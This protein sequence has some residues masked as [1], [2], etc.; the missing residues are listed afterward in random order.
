MVIWSGIIGFGLYVG[1]R[2]DVGDVWVV[3]FWDWGNIIGFNVWVFGLF[4]GCMLGW[5]GRC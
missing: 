1:C 5:L 2:L 3:V 4:R